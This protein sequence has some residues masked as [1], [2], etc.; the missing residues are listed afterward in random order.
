ME[1]AKNA[2]GQRRA[3]FSNFPTYWIACWVADCLGISEPIK[4]P[5][6]NIRGWFEGE[7]CFNISQKL[8]SFRLWRVA[9][10]R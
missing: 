6:E 2:L 3:T 7:S 4:K 8:I 5:H 10:W 1:W 9:A